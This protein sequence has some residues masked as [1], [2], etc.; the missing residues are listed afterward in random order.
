[1]QCKSCNQLFGDGERSPRIL[2][3]C[4]HTL[5][6][7]CIA[8][9]FHSNSV[10]CMQCKHTSYAHSIQDFPINQILIKQCDPQSRMLDILS[11]CTKH[12]KQLDAYCQKDKTLLCID[13]ILIDGH[14]AHEIVPILQA[15]EMV[16]EK[17]IKCKAECAKINN[18]IRLLTNS[19]ESYRVWINEKANQSREL[20]TCIFTEIKSAI[21]ERESQLMQ[22]ISVILEK[23]EDCIN[24]KLMQIKQHQSAYQIFQDEVE[25]MQSED[26]ITILQNYTERESL[27][28]E[29]AKQLPTSQ[30]YAAFPDISKEREWQNIMKLLGN[31]PKQPPLSEQPGLLKKKETFSK[32]KKPFVKEIKKNS[33]N[34][35]IKRIYQESNKTT[36]NVSNGNPNLKGNLIPKNTIG[37]TSPM[38][39]ID[40][41]QISINMSFN[42]SIANDPHSKDAVNENII[43]SFANGSANS[44]KIQHGSPAMKSKIELF[45]N[46]S[47][48]YKAQKAHHGIQKPH[49]FNSII[50][51][52]NC[53]ESMTSASNNKFQKNESTFKILAKK[54]ISSPSKACGDNNPPELMKNSSPHE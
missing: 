23:E 7:K 13:C 3:S 28:Q 40:D 43:S 49:E 27:S 25:L 9:H 35:S 12:N 17:L 31:K 1:M 18:E 45:K 39:V 42:N 10:K 11:T 48:H 6:Q 47:A 15:S 30:P 33:L 50:L 41:G 44:S 19:L 16:K 5:C 54:E 53:S 14:K 36:R 26:S 20:T 22:D 32:V 24:A 2:I 51:K 34:N 8:S 46:I 29:A 37:V 21:S 4:G 52:S 38:H